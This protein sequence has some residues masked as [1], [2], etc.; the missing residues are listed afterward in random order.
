MNLTKLAQYFSVWFL[1]L[2]IFHGIV[3]GHTVCSLFLA[4]PR[5]VH[6]ALRQKINKCKSLANGGV[7]AVVIA[8]VMKIDLFEYPR[9]QAFE[10]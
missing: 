8:G 10:V 9:R 3:S 1:V 6:L 2:S 4:V 5:S 7:L